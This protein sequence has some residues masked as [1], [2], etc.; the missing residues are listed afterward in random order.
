MV[1]KNNIFER[2]NLSI[3]RKD[4][5]KDLKPCNSN[6]LCCNFKEV[7]IFSNSPNHL[8]MVKG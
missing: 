6:N 4:N 2:R 8:E 7:T 1:K 5:S 3:S